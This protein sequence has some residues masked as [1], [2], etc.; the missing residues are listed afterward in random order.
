M[1]SRGLAAKVENP[2]MQ[3]SSPAGT[4]LPP[5]KAKMEKHCGERFA[6]SGTNVRSTW[7]HTRTHAHPY[8]RC[9]VCGV[10]QVCKRKAL[11]DVR[12]T[13]VRTEVLSSSVSETVSR[14]LA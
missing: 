6:S 12:E 9:Q 10:S 13:R 3:L 2:S 14:S 8:T 5:T 7:H 1:L 11:P 4:L